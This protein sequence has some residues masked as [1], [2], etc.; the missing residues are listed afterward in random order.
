[1]HM[2]T[3]QIGQRR[4]GALVRNMREVDSSGVGKQHGAETDAAAGA[5]RGIVKLA[6]LRFRERDQFLHIVRRH[7]LV[8]QDNERAGGNQA[9]WCKILARVVAD[10]RI[11]CRIDGERAGATKSE[12]IAVG[13]RL[14]DLAGADAF[15]IGSATARANTS[16]PPPGA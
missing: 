8:H 10:I 16:L 12:R 13:R 2:P 11:E 15:P 4:S 6:R 9:D 14:G 1:M 3:E 5:G 7:R